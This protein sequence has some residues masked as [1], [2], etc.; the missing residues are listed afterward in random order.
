MVNALF[1]DFAIT[2]M[3]LFAAYLLRRKI[4]I[5][6]KV[7]L[8]SAIIAGI[9]G[10][11]LG[12]YVLGEFSPVYIKYS[13]YIGQTSLPLMCCVLCSQLFLVNLDR[14]TIKQGIRSIILMSVMLFAQVI[15]GVLIVRVLMK[16]Q[17]DVYG[18][19]P[20]TSFHC[21]AGICST[22]T[23]LI[24]D[25]PDFSVEVGNAIGNTYATI[26]M[27][28]GM[29][30][31]MIV[32]NVARRKGILASGDIVSVTEEE[33]TGFVPAEKRG[34]AAF[35]VTNSQSI[36]TMSLH[37]AIGGVIIG[38]GM[39][40][41]KIVPIFPHILI[42][43][44]LSGLVLGF[45]FKALKWDAIVDL[46]SIKHFGS[47]ALDF[48]MTSV[49][50]NTNIHVFVDYGALIIVTSLVIMAAN[51][52]IIFGL[53]KLWNGKHWIENS[54]GCYGTCNGVAATGLMLLK[55]ADPY[56]ASGA[57]APFSTA[58]SLIGVC[59]QLPFLTV[60]PLL[61]VNNGNKVLIG[62]AIAFVVYTAVG[63]LLA[64]RQ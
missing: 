25:R 42:P 39:L 23:V 7:F 15:I 56:D 26:S 45:V 30:I 9:L 53:G 41:H 40:F 31:G 60:I 21:G 33:Y 2:G 13:E 24:G 37:F 3:L 28:T 48:L 5:F 55:T 1:G 14:A 57:A 49:I 51:L 27:I 11:L 46:R 34:P 62:T 61:L 35:D 6:Q 52:I 4:R 17:S 50:A 32:I 43:V 12:P 63:F 47:I 18:L 38:C 16:G 36:N 22:V 54:I 44:T 58:V 29:I 10:I 64:E 20:F 8:P 19:L 59:S